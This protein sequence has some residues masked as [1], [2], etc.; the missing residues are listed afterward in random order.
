MDV[1]IDNKKVH[2]EKK[3]FKSL[4]LVMDEINKILDKEGKMLSD[5]YVNGNIIYDNQIIPGDKIDV[6]EV[7][8][9]SPK[10]VILRALGDMR[11]FF[12]SFFEKLEIIA[13]EV[14]Y[15]DEV[16]MI[17]SFFEIIGGLEWCSNV[18]LSIKEN[19]ALDFVDPTFDEL[20]ETYKELLTS[21][22]DALNSRDML[23]LYEM[24]EFEMSDL[25]ADL[26]KYLNT[27]Y[28]IILKEELRDGKFA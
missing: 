12:D 6:V 13:T 24:L 8:T 22:I 19:T 11:D 9:Q 18:L 14:E 1:I 7:I 20:L 21:L 5:L 15:D 26:S 17:N 2:L 27:Y 16:Q 3:R 10:M 4:G 25:I 28:E 23:A